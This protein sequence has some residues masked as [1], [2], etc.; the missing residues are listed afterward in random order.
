MSI[1]EDSRAI[2]NRAN[3]L[4]PNSN[5]RIESWDRV[6]FENVIRAILEHMERQDSIVLELA[7]GEK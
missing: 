3:E 2:L 1:E 5:F 7:K 6:K 4:A